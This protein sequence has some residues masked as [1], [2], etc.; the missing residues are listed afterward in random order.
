[1]RGLPDSPQT[2]K[3]RLLDGFFYFL[4]LKAYF[5]KQGNEKTNTAKA[6]GILLFVQDTLEGST[7]LIPVRLAGISYVRA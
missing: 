4:A 2:L 5:Y 3:T 7:M 1:L 6:V